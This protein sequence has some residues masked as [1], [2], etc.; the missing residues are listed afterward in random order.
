MAG[1]FLETSAGARH[2]N[3]GEV[4]R[5]GQRL[6]V[7]G[8]PGYLSGMSTLDVVFRWTVGVS[9]LAHAAALG[10]VWGTIGHQARRVALPAS[11]DVWL[12]TTVSVVQEATG[13]S[14]PVSPEKEKTS[15]TDDNSTAVPDKHKFAIPK[16]PKSQVTRVEDSKANEPKA[17]AKA[18]SADKSQQSSPAPAADTPSVASPGASI[19]LKQAMVDAANQ[20]VSGSGTFGAVGVDLRERR[21]PAAFTRALPVAIGAEPSWWRNHAGAQGRVQFEVSL[22][23]GGKIKD[24]TVEDETQ[25][26]FLARIVRRV[27]RLLAVGRYALPSLSAP[28]A[29]QRFELRLDLQDGTPSSNETAEAGDAIDMGWEAPSASGP[30]KAHIQEAKGRTMRAFLKLLPP[31]QQDDGSRNDAPVHEE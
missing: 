21:L 4:P 27:G 13:H 9:L 8:A 22:D 10:S 12:G 28:N 7:K 24:V 5:N 25:H 3:V 2:T 17:I 19:D 18:P 20:K 26:A 6:Q 23:E 31:K 15:S 16:S 29:R 11:Q 30:G 14:V 1:P